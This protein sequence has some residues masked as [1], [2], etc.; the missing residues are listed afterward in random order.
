MR[1][2]FNDKTFP[3]ILI[4]ILSSQSS[5]N[6]INFKSKE[7]CN[8]TVNHFANKKKGDDLTMFKEEIENFI[9]ADKKETPKFTKKE[10]SFF[11]FPNISVKQI[12]S[13]WHESLNPS[14]NQFY[15]KHNETGKNQLHQAYNK[16]IIEQMGGI[17]TTIN[18]YMNL[19]NFLTDETDQKLIF[20]FMQQK[21]MSQLAMSEIMIK[22]FYNNCIKNFLGY[23]DLI[24]KL[25][26]NY[27]ESEIFKG[28]PINNS[29]E[30]VD[31]ITEQ[32]TY[33]NS[34]KFYG[35]MLQNFVN[36]IQELINSQT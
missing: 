5:F 6:F 36:E 30:V 11:E 32:V 28:S 9:N 26:S 2:K 21:W 31:L 25:D 13:S 34:L 3:Q 12:E 16:I 23:Q 29:Y 8:Q 7:S 35:N 33:F 15:N 1:K 17:F 20:N 4:E 14:I 24:I 22:I 19:N 27:K 10:N 18:E